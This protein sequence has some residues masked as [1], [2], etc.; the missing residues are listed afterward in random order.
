MAHHEHEWTCGSVNR[1]G[2]AKYIHLIRGPYDPEKSPRVKVGEPGSD[3]TAEWRRK[4]KTS[5]AKD[6]E[7]IVLELL[8]DG[9]PRT[10]NEIGIT[11]LDRT[12]D[13]LRALPPDEALWNLVERCELEHTM[14]A[15]I[16]FRTKGSTQKPRGKAGQDRPTATRAPSPAP[17]PGPYAR[18]LAE[19]L[20]QDEAEAFALGR[21]EAAKIPFWVE[22]YAVLIEKAKP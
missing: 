3:P 22:V 2:V 16:Y 1:K 13:N 17:S 12:A 15:P 4:L 8:A 9:C 19:A 21:W 14:E 6:W 10:L 20:G 7:P 18:E 11:L 5:S